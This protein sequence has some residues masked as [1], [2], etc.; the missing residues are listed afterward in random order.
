MS[1]A[2]R[3]QQSTRV[4]SRLCSVVAVG[5]AALAL[6]ASASAQQVSPRLAD[7]TDAPAK[8]KLTKV[9]EDP[10]TN[11]TA[12]HRTQVEA[13]TYAWGDT[14]VAGFQTGRYSNGGATNNGWATSV[15]GGQTWTHGFLPGTTPQADP[16]GPYPRVSD[17][18]VAYDARHDV[19][20][21]NSL[22]V[23]AGNFLIVNRS[24]DGGLTWKNPLL[25]EEPGSAAYDKNWIA[26][27]NW[28]QSPHYGN[29]YVQAD[30]TSLSNR[31]VMFASSDGGRNWTKATVPVATGLGG[32]PLAQPDGTVVVPYSGNLN[33]VQSLVSEDG[34]LTYTGPF[35]VAGTIDHTVPFM[36]APALPSA[37]V[38]KNGRVYVVW[39]DCRFRTGCPTN[40]I[41]MSTS[42]DG[43]TWSDPVRIP[44]DG[45]ASTVDHFTPGIGVDPTTG[46]RRAHLALT[47]N[48][49]PTDACTL[50]TCELFAGYVSSTN[51]GKS[52]SSPKTLV[53]PMNLRWLPDAA[54]RFVGDY[55]S[56]SIMNGRAFPVFARAKPGT[57]TLGMIE[58]CDE[59]MV[60]PKRGLPVRGGDV[61]ASDDPVVSASSD[62]AAP[63]DPRAS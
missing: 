58:S 15:D 55:M 33:N 9:S 1:L 4:R 45:L 29:C 41:V 42:D 46:G 6:T 51:R 5:A 19:W 24:T 36:R 48:Y 13:D 56:T 12:Y 30:D 37:E 57:C 22:T 3:P 8:V 49:F 16:P 10:Y 7:T 62:H 47:Y 25:V 53:G 63:T 18:V 50:D 59:H 23:G 17:P 38:D 43:S 14:V 27:D 11:P 61:P 44:I 31:M 2:P 54:G 39:Q 35:A 52:W 32:L 34:G 60:A 28:A 40:D 20:L 26:C 21:F